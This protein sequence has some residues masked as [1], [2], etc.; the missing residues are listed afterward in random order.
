MSRALM[1]AY[2]VGRD[3][4][5]DRDG[6]GRTGAVGGGHE[7]SRGSGIAVL[8][9]TQLLRAALGLLRL[10]LAA[11]HAQRLSLVQP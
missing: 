9:A 4:A 1:G 5:T 8:L 6:Q 7:F 2:H 11:Q 3:G 10:R